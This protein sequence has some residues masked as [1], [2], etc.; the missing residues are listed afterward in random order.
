M[1]QTSTEPAEQSSQS[2]ESS[3][4]APNSGT[5]RRGGFLLVLKSLAWLIVPVAIFAGTHFYRHAMTHESTDDAFIAGHIIPISSRVAAHVA[6]VHVTDNQ[7]VKAGDLLVELSPEDFSARLQAAKAALA[8][9][10]ASFES[11]RIDVELTTVTASSANDEARANVETAKA[12]H[13]TAQA[14]YAA[15]VSQYE[16]ARAQLDSTTASLAQAEADVA[17]AKAPQQRDALDLK[18]NEELVRTGAVSQQELNHAWTSERM[19]AASVTAAQTKVQTQRAAVQQ[20]QA[21]L[22]AAEENMRQAKAQISA[23]KAQLEE[24]QARLKAALSV[25]QKVAKS[26]S[27]AQ[28]SQAEIDK[29]RAEFELARL[30]LSYTRICAPTDGFV[31]SRAA[32]PGAY[33]QVGQALMAVV[34]RDVWVVANFKET[35][36]TQMRPGQP[37]KIHVDVYPQVTFSGHIDSV[38]HG[39][40]A[41][42][43]LLPPENATGNF[44]KLVQRIPVKIAFDLPEQSTR[45]LL[46]PGMSVTP[47]VDI[48]APAAKAAP[49]HLPRTVAGFTRPALDLSPSLALQNKADPQ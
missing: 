33:V 42:F 20:A 44:V 28:A 7:W 48:A 3:P 25:P 22:K 8:A 21:G 47:E 34:P 2:P 15:A 5:K 12:Q 4:Q 43:S 31:T 30:N 24:S 17:F 27:E 11:S 9:A 23:R 46:A 49:E 10:Q 19:S 14:L 45:F 39:T 36:L 26:R 37:V 40:G 32:E 6:A 16:Q 1:A 35:Q 38:Q 29:A 41:A 13:E 18:R